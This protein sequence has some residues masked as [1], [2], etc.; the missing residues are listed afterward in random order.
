M[1]NKKT[2]KKVLL[3][4]GALILG[5][6][7][8]IILVTGFE[9]KDEV[10]V[11]FIMTGNTQEQ[12]WNRLHY[13]GILKACNELDVTLLVKEE[14][15]ENTGQCEQAI[16]EL[17]EEEA[18]M[19]ILS[20][21]GYAQEVLPVVE[22]YPEVAFYSESFDHTASNMKSY[23]ARMYQARYLAGIVAGMQTKSDCIGYV[24]AMPNN[25]V[26]RGINAFTLG[27][28]RVNPN[29]Q[30]VVA[31]SNSWDDAAKEKEQAKKLIEEKQADVLAYHQNQPNVVDVAEE[32]GVAS[33]GYH[34]APPDVSDNFLTA[35]VFHWDFT[36]KEVLLDYIRE[37]SD[38]V[39]SY[40]I[41]IEQDAVGLSEFS[42]QVSEETIAEVERAKKEMITG[43]DVFSGEIYDCDGALRC[44]D[45][46]T[47]SD[48]KLVKHMDWYVEGVEVYEN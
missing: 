44:S 11:G 27:V 5:V 14:I 6:I 21:Y 46:E 20:S 40:W 28:R 43:F 47:M 16:R 36:Y 45:G 10:K 38:A 3:A 4:A 19:I 18:D 32:Y 9:K 15:K 8:A 35:A 31:W 30:V 22:A 13:E 2:W 17:V 37:K 42:A 39:T 33:I 48:E 29:A 7:V 34:E 24:A 12:G 41:G 25:E 26:N 1:K 23:F